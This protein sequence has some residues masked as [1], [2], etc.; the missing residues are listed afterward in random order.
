MPSQTASSTRSFRTTTYSNGKGLS[1]I[2]ELFKNVS[3][4]LNNVTRVERTDVVVERNSQLLL[5]PLTFW[6]KILIVVVPLR[7]FNLV[8]FGTNA[9]LP[10]FYSN[11]LSPFIR[12]H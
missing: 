12:K 7:F 6:L 2:K 9:V 5:R 3:A 1:L 4:K 11:I 10:T 8:M